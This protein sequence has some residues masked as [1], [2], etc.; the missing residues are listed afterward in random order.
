MKKSTSLLVL[1][2]A[3]ILLSLTACGS[4][5]ESPKAT[6]SEES[7]AQTSSQANAQGKYGIGDKI[8]FDGQAEYTITG[9]EWSEERNQFDQ[10]HPEKVLK[11][12][13][14]VTNLS[15]KDLLIGSDIDLYVG[16]KKMGTYPNIVD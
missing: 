4:K 8:T 10:S 2:S 13:Y 11:V 7:T 6:S 5:I 9:V 14:N 1:W 16:G 3:G 15:D 12:S